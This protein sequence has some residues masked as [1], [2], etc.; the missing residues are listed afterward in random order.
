MLGQQLLGVGVRFLH[1]LQA[2][3]M[4][5]LQNRFG[6]RFHT[7]GQGQSEQGFSVAGIGFLT[8]AGKLASASESVAKTAHALWVRAAVNAMQEFLFVE[9]KIAGQ[10]SLAGQL[11]KEV[12]GRDCNFAKWLFGISG[13]PV[14]ETVARF[15][16]FLLIEEIEAGAQLWHGGEGWRGEVWR[17]ARKSGNGTQAQ[18]QKREKI[19]VTLHHMYLSLKTVCPSL[20]SQG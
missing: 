12:A 17:F 18:Q 2:F 4:P 1:A 5:F 3:E 13:F 15:R 10:H 6:V 7:G 11:L 9:E 14:R 8:L 16:K 19:R 20:L